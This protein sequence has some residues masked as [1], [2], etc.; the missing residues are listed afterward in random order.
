MSKLKYESHSPYSATQQVHNYVDYLDYWN[1]SYIFPNSNDTLRLLEAKYNRRPD[2]LAYDLY[3]T[4]N[5]FWVFMMRN[6]D[7]IKDP[8]WDFVTGIPIYTPRKDSL[9]RFM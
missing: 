8:I 5:L 3:G 1:G 4:P 7:I 2:L 9:N 6:P